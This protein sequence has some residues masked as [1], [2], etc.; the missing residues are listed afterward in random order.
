ML[1]GMNMGVLFNFYTT[2]TFTLPGQAMK[3]GQHTL[4]FD[5]ASNTHEDIEDAVTNVTINCQPRT[6]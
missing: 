5:L 2:R 4:T 1:D 6:K 3:L